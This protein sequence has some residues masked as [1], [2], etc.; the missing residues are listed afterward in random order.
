MIKYVPIYS[1]IEEAK[2]EKQFPY[3]K[4]CN[5]SNT[6]DIPDLETAIQRNKDLTNVIL[7]NISIFILFLQGI[8]LIAFIKN[9]FPGSGGIKGSSKISS[10]I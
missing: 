5:N 9:N 2:L 3:Q 6:S 7:R 8:Y 4:Q 10:D 1:E